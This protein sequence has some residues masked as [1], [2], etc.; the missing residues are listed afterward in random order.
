MKGRNNLS[1][2]EQCNRPYM[3][4]FPWPL[5]RTMI[6]SF[7][8][9]GLLHYCFPG[10]MSIT[11]LLF[12]LATARTAI[13]SSIVG[14]SRPS[15]GRT[16]GGVRSHCTLHYAEWRTRRAEPLLGRQAFTLAA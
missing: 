8:Q 15:V 9:G 1:D 5:F 6:V 16:I 4:L 10:G 11:G 12:P 7:W 14:L 3:T 2:F 13:V